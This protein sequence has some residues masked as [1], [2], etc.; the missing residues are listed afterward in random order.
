MPLTE[1]GRQKLREAGARGGAKSRGKLSPKTLETN[2]VLAEYRQQILKQVA[3]L[4]RRNMIPAMGCTYVYKRVE[5]KRGKTI[6]VEKV[7][8]EDPHEIEMALNMI[9]QAEGYDKNGK[10][11]AP[12]Y[13]I[14]V[15]DPDWRAIESLMNRV[16]GKAKETVDLNAR[17]SMGQFESMS[18]DELINLI[19]G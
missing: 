4:L 15:K 17:H 5:E 16:F 6:F 14:V 9:D 2:R 13:Y 11:G 7:L 10:D 12:Y 3:V 8:V 1:A 18:N 19:E